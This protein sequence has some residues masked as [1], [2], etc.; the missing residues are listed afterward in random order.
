ME[1]K[2]FYENKNKFISKKAWIVLIRTPFP[3]P[4]RTEN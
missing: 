1:N 2:Y 3:F 4:E